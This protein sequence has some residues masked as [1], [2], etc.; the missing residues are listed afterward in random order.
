MQI[1][2]FLLVSLS[3]ELNSHLVLMWMALSWSTPCRPWTIREETRTPAL[4]SN[5]LQIIYSTLHP[6]E[7]CQRSVESLFHRTWSY[8]F[9]KNLSVINLCLPYLQICILITDGRS[10]DSVQEPAQ[11][12]RSQGV[13]I[14]AVGRPSLL[15]FLSR[16]E[17]CF[18]LKLMKRCHVFVN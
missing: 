18:F 5:M 6:G 14:F 4:V 2:T 11:K 12:L 9:N 1:Y 10:Q 15:S 16:R 7:M 3:S 13:H 8:I 17:V